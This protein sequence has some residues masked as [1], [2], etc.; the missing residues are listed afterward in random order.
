MPN[1]A[2]TDAAQNVLPIRKNES[3]ATPAERPR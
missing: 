2:A 1:I 3:E